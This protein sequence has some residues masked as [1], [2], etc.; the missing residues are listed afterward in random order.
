LS[1][2]DNVFGNS[3]TGYNPP[4]PSDNGNEF[5]RPRKRRGRTALIASLTSVVV[6]LGAGG[7]AF[8][9]VTAGPLAG[10]FAPTEDFEGPGTGEVLFTINEGDIGDVIANNLVDAGV[11]MSFDPFYKLLLEADPQ[12]VFV[13]GVYTLKLGMS[14]QQALDALQNP[15]IS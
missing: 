11:I 7:T 1:G 8:W 3:P 2:F 9:A 13:P 6:L 5:D 10:V 12:V 15:T 4:N 14:S